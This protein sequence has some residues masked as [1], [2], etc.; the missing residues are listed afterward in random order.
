MYILNQ[1]LALLMQFYITNWNSTKIQ[2]NN[3]NDDNNYYD[4]ND[5]DNIVVD[6][7]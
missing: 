7:S 4:D 6:N 5:D 3:D 1:F 2:Y